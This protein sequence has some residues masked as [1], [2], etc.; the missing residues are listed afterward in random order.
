MT[1]TIEVNDKF[2]DKFFEFIN[3]FKNEIKI[4][5]EDFNDIL[6]FNEAKKDK[7]NMKSIDE[8]LKEYKIES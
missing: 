7:S 4:K 2:S 6:L 1:L 5:N 3:N 8:L